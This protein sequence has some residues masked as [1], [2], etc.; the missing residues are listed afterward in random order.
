MDDSKD[1]TSATESVHPQALKRLKTGAMLSL[2]EIAALTEHPVPEDFQLPTTYLTQDSVSRDPSYKPVSR[3]P[4]GRT[5][6]G[7]ELY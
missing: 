1:L 2:L 4:I 7:R 6:T 3:H 5:P